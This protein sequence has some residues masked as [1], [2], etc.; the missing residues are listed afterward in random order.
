MIFSKSKLKKLLKLLGP[1]I[2]IFIFVR[3]VD[4]EATFRVLKAIRLDLVLISVLFFPIVNAALTLRWWLI[5]R[6][7][8]IH[9]SFNELFQ[10]YYVAWFLSA[11]PLVGVSPLAK[12]LYLKE[13]GKPAGTSV[14]SITL[15]KLFDII[16]L[17]IFGLFG[18]VY[19]PQSI[20]NK[21]EIWIVIGSC[22]ML[23]I[24]LW[25]LRNR[26]WPALLAFL[27]RYT[28]RRLQKIGISLQADLKEFWSRFNVR[29]FL[30]IM[31]VS[32]AIGVL[33][34]LVLYIL[35][36]ALH[37]SVGFGVIVACRAI[38][39]LVNVIPVTISG[40]GTRDAVLLLMLPLA[41]ATQ[42][43]AI[44]LGMA[45]FLWTIVSKFSGVFFWLNR[46]LPSGSFRN[47]KERVNS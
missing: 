9:E 33:R 28:T 15:D 5:C 37:I 10:V 34:A 32:I 18:I 31:G 8:A 45:A 1:F 39:G 44:A 22:L 2:F 40:L 46:P 41:G 42:E 16:G 21:T 30:L 13:L 17:L 26:V 23:M 27:K 14:V 7:L 11:L 12:M 29:F 24:V 20:S 36:V 19:F 38:I 35:A 25:G 6:R 47:T 4:M 43:A 3:V